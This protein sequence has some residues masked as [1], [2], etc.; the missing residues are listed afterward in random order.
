MGQ[1][2]LPTRQS[3]ESGSLPRVSVPR[4]PSQPRT[5]RELLLDLGGSGLHILALGEECTSLDL[6]SFAWVKCLLSLTAVVTA[7]PSD[8]NVGGP[9]HHSQG[10]LTLKW[11]VPPG[12]AK[13]LHF[14]LD[15][16]SGAPRVQDGSSKEESQGKRLLLKRRHLNYILFSN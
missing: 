5:D 12:E 2:P 14:C 3:L 1:R 16:A 8:L 7:L 15:P 6:P 4:A 9:S 13:P 11:S 10:S